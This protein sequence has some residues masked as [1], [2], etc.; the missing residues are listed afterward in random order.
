MTGL[1][2]TVLGLAIPGIRSRIPKFLESRTAG[3]DFFK[4]LLKEIEHFSGS[5]AKGPDA[6]QY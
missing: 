4:S 1:R 3:R 5:F 6:K 2:I